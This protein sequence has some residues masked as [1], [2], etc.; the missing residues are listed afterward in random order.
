MH[1][2]TGAKHDASAGIG[3]FDPRDAETPTSSNHLNQGELGRLPEIRSLARRKL[4]RVREAV[5]AF[6]S[7][8]FT[9]LEALE[10]GGAARIVFLVSVAQRERTE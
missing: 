3:V 1:G 4:V 9:Q 5:D 2:N 6:Q 7:L 8:A 10:Q